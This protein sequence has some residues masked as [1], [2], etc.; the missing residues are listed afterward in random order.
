MPFTEDL[1]QFFEQDEFAVAAVIKNGPTV[2]RSIS[3]IFNTPTQEAAI[4]DAGAEVNVP[5]MQCQTSDLTGVTK[6]H[7]VTIN[8]VAYRIG[9]REDDGTGVSTVQL[10]KQ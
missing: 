5:F 3:V 9:E 7:T 6:S 1:S 8:G 4:F 10:R 2:I